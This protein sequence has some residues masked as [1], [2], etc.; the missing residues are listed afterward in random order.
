MNSGYVYLADRGMDLVDHNLER[1]RNQRGELEP[2]EIGRVMNRQCIGK[3]VRVP[4]DVR[5]EF[6]GVS[7]SIIVRSRV[8]RHE[9]GI[10]QVQVRERHGI[11]VLVRDAVQVSVDPKDFRPEP[12]PDR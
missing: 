5:V 4:G 7:R 8:P 2:I 11:D 10:N 6:D 12:T 1:P 3:L 9:P